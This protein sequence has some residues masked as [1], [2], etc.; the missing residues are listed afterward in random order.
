MRDETRMRAYH[1]AAVISSARAIT[2]LMWRGGE[3]EQRA[4]YRT[5]SVERGRG[6][7]DGR[8]T[9]DGAKRKR[10]FASKIFSESDRAAEKCEGP[11][12]SSG[13]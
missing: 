9:D 10:C 11:L 1:T 7:D 8:S 13:G 5:D 3:E 12:C 6:A 2:Q 4:C